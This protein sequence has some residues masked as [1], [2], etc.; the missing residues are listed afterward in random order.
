[1]RSVQSSAFKGH[2]IM[3][4]QPART[5]VLEAISKCME[6]AQATAQATVIVLELAIWALTV[7]CSVKENAEMLAQ[8]NGPQ[9]VIC[10]SCVLCTWHARG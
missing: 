5:Q 9:L 7:M 1:L 3:L 6:A 8:A 2:E 4:S 10:L